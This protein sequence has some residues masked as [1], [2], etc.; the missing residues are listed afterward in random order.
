[1]T[2]L[3]RSLHATAPR[4]ARAPKPTDLD[5]HDRA[6]GHLYFRAFAPRG[7]PPDAPDITTWAIGPFPGRDFHPLDR[8]RYGLHGDLVIEGMEAAIPILLSAAVEHALESTNPVHALGAADGS[9]RFGTHQSPS[10]PSRASM[11]RGPFPTWPAFPTS[12]YY[13]PLRL[14][15][16]HPGHF[17]GSPVI[18][19]ASLPATPQTGGAETALPSSQDDHPHVQRPIRRRVHQ[20]PLLDQERLPWPSPSPDRLGSLYSRP[21]AGPLD[22][23]CSGFTH[24]ADRAVAPAPLRTRPL[25]HARGLHY[26]GPRHLP[27]PD[28]HRQAALNLSL[29]RHLVLLSSWRRSS[30]GAPGER[31]SA[32]PRQACDSR[33]GPAARTRRLRVGLVG[34]GDTRSMRAASAQLGPASGVCQRFSRRRPRRSARIR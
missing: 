33:G 10:H 4:V 6:V 25:D 9:S 12:E 2:T 19:R 34:W 20:R 5:H 8:C 21:Q 13:D 29:L 18:G 17:P 15:L 28:S 31:T 24:V 32:C 11:K 26:R 22:D 7:H 3:Q 27:G 23:A 30:L 1:M 16:D 14:P